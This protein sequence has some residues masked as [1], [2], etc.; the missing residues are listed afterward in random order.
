MNTIKNFDYDWIFN[1]TTHHNYLITSVNKIINTI[2]TKQLSHLDVGCGN[3]YLTKSISS[4]FDA[5]LGIDL[6]D[7]GIRQSKQY[8]N[9]K[10][11]FKN[12]DTEQLI[13]DNLKFDFITSFEVVE[14]QYLP[15]IFLNNINKLLK[16]DG[17]FLVSTPYHGY[18]KNLAI[19]LLNKND[20]HFNPLWRHGHI[21]FFS[22][23]TFK[24]TLNDANF[25][26]IKYSFSGR[27]YP[28]SCSMVFLCKK[29]N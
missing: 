12:I 22:I 13:K 4:K 16:K 29:I 18:L 1:D 9:D 14:H 17:H 11:N 25:E 2:N 5:S 8:S 19:S 10:L 26:V 6:S 28:F 23:K 24:K 20:W 15:D 3:G 21:K 27:F 7:E